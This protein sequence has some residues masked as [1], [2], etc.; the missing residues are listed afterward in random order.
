M[1]KIFCTLLITIAF[2]ITA[3]AQYISVSGTVKSSADGLPLI[4]VN[5]IVKNSSSGAVSD[6]DGNFTISNVASNATLVFTYIGFE[7]LELPATSVMNV[8]LA[9][10]NESLDEVVLIGYGSKSKKDLT[11]AVSI[12]GSET[13][14]KLKPVDV[15]QALQGTTTGVSVSTNSGSPGSGF[16]FLIRGVSS[17]TDNDPLLVVDGYIVSS[18]NS[19]NPD[20]IESLTVLK[21]AQ[22]AIYGVEGA[23]GV[24]LV[25][26]KRGKKNSAPKV[27]YNTYAGIQETTKKL[28]LLNASEYAA[29]VNESYAANGQALPY[30]NIA[31]LGAGTNWQDELFNQALMTNH[32]VS[33]SGGT[34]NITYYL[35]AT[36]L[37]QDGIIASDK[38]N[39]VRDNVKLNLGV[40][41]NDRLKTTLNLNY[42]SNKRK[43]INESGLGSV[44]FNAISYS[45]LFALDQEDL[46]PIFGNEIINPFS[47]IRDTYNTYFGSSIEGNFQLEYK[48]TDDL[49]VTSRMGF[50]TYSDKGKIFSPI[51]DYG[52]NKVFNTSRSTVNQSKNQYDSYTWDTF[53]TYKKSIVDKHNVEAT[54][55]T[56]VIKNWGDGLFA[57]GF[58]V[59]NNSWDFADIALTTGTSDAK[60]NGSYTYDN[61]LLSYFGRLQYDFKGKYLLSA[62]IR[63]DGS[64]A[65]VKDNRIDYFKSFTAGWKISDENFLKDSNVI[66]FLKIRG[67]YGTLGNL[68]GNDLYRAALSGEATYVFDGALTNGVAN[69]PIANPKAKW[70]TAEKLDIGLDAKFFGNKLEIVADYFLEDR[71]DLLIPGLP[72]SGI[73]GTTAPGSGSPTV[74][75]GTTRSEGLEFLINYSDNI[76]DDL[77]YNVSYNVTKI[78][79]TV[80]D[81]NAEVPLTGGSFGVGQPLPPSRM[82]NGK[83]IGY[84]YG[85]QT[86]GI[87]QTQADVDAHPS[88]AS[89]GAVTSPGDIRFVDVNGDGEINSDDRT[90]IGKPLADYYM[91][92]NFSVNYKSFDLSVYTYAELGKDMVRNYERDQPN[93]NRLDYYLDRWTGPG[94]SNTVPRATTGATTNKLFSDFYVEDASFVRIQNIQLGYSLPQGVLEKIGMSQVRLY[95]SVNNAFTFTKYKGFDP[96]ATTG[97]ALGG[98]IDPGFYPTVRQYILGLNISF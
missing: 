96:A 32:N 50:K 54:V 42:F 64:S 4:G 19:L 12:V 21:D 22:A 28:S 73:L 2:V 25:T 56:T 38:S 29:L 67:S 84:F 51:V 52:P 91:G 93:V 78:E 53:A 26:T 16:R 31:G 24:I 40:D 43:T 74:N 69:G 14:E 5:I 23:N 88:Q 15:S 3:N 48:L 33:F 41:V 45:P 98:G 85:L 60:E 34:D 63:R 39:Y 58:D 44:L 89:L 80:I 20:D 65:F 18:F 47:Q 13:I 62:M 1:K 8:E 17:N 57:T 36:R 46:A 79:G 10:D 77:S 6:F 55:G 92:F 71:V 49:T 83:P 76:T 86:D 87:F 66:D 30:S 75:A 37:D 7:T 59:P 95:A 61:R 35:G 27:T 94:T 70:E 9:E 97:E 90:F 81:V 11:G 68:V 82:E 72:V